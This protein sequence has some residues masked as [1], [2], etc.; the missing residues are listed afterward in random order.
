ML[1]DA[2]ALNP[3][4]DARTNPNNQALADALEILGYKGVYHMREV[5]KNGHHAAWVELINAK[6][7]G[8][9]DQLTKCD[10]EPLL[11]NFEAG[12]IFFQMLTTRLQ[13]CKQR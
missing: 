4:I 10:F 1:V 2:T 5:G 3:S 9:G 7:A 11:Q 8:R 6:I 12:V 13:Q